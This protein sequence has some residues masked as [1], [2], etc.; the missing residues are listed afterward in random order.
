MPTRHEL[1]A[2][3]D[4]LP[5]RILA[6]FRTAIGEPRYQLWFPPNARLVWFGADVLLVCRNQHFQD[7]ASEKF[8]DALRTAVREACGDAHS[9]KFVTDADMFQPSETTPAPAKIVPTKLALDLPYPTNASPQLN[10]FGEAAPPL[11]IRDAKRM[12][13]Q[14]AEK[15]GKPMRRW[16]TFAEFVVGPSNRV[17]HAAAMSL[18]EDPG[19]C[20]N[21]LVLHGPVGTGKTHLLEAIAAGLR[22]L[23]PDMRPVYITAEEFTTRAVQAMRFGKTSAFRRQF[24][25]CPALLLDDLNFLATKRATQ[26]EFLHTLDALVAEGRPVVLTTDCHPRLAE[27][28]MPELVD[29]LLG[30]TAWSLMPP[31]DETR[32]NILRAKSVSSPIPFGEESLKFV[33]RS[34]RGN[35]RELEGAVNNIRHFAKVTNRPITPNLAREA[36]G[37][38]LRHT[39]R[40]VRVADIDAAVCQVL[41]LSAGTLQSKS[42]SWSVCHPRMVA[43]YLAR[44]LTQATY[45][46]IAKHFGVRQHST[47]VAGEKKVRQWLTAKQTLALGD[48]K[49]LVA[50]LLERIEREVQK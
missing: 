36:L 15:S 40:A 34:L 10:L 24:R 11:T 19:A 38:L 27:E 7:W 48:R 46:E 22:K 4:D 23:G 26:E 30:G 29:R 50:D 8:G 13:Q 39:V 12:E 2:S 18:L 16:K 25:E 47:A 14:K 37:D 31:D 43:I 45:G 35:V 49:W 1:P 17:A 9:L 44:K 5:S 32:L 41:N 42:R 28:L 33:A 21:P 3:A 6:S 20:P